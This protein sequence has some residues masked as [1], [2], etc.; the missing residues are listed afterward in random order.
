[1]PIQDTKMILNQIIPIAKRITNSKK[2][3]LQALPVTIKF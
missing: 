1:M 2:T 3:D